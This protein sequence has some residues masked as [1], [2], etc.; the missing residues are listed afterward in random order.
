MM[1][2]MRTSWTTTRAAVVNLS[3]EMS[4]LRESY[5]LFRETFLG[6]SNASMTSTIKR[7]QK[8]SK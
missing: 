8:T 1:M 3:V 7:I 6:L 2:K 5:V 4:F